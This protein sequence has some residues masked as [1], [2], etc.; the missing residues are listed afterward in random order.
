MLAAL[1]AFKDLQCAVGVHLEF[2][3]AL[4]LVEDAE[5]LGHHL[6]RSAC[7]TRGGFPAAK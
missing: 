5:P 1:D 6:H 7:A 3:H 2:V 4:E